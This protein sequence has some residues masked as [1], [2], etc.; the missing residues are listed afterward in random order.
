MSILRSKKRLIV[1]GILVLAAAIGAGIA[2][3]TVTTAIL[4]DTTS[5]RLRI[6]RSEFVPSADQPEFSSG[7]HTH[8]GPIIV[9]VQEG[10]LK[11][12]QAT[13]NPNVIGPGDTFIETPDL[14]VNATA[15]KAVK[16]TTSMIL[17]AGAALS[18]PTTSPC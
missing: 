4:T 11:L 13:C 16:W 7:W 6:V 17:P 2:V 18:T 5:V 12:Y 9:Q 8:P 14:P 3:A 1:V 10:Y 15:N